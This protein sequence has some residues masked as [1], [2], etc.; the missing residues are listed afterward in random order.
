ME[1]IGKIIKSTP[2][3]FRAET[4]QGPFHPERTGHFGLMLTQD[5]PEGDFE[6]LHN[7]MFVQD[8]EAMIRDFYQSED[9]RT[10]TLQ[11][12][13]AF[14]VLDDKGIEEMNLTDPDSFDEWILARSWAYSASDND[15]GLICFLYWKLVGMAELQSR[16]KR[17][18]D[19]EVNGDIEWKEQS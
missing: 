14:G 18:E 16:L 13:K 6:M 19:A 10:W 12:F 4:E 15:T 3:T 8:K 11:L 17:Y 9:L 5:E 7:S 1:H 2:R